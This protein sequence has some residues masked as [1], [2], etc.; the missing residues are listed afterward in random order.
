MNEEVAGRARLVLQVLEDFPVIH[1]MYIAAVK[2][3][4]RDHYRR[5]GD[6]QSSSVRPRSSIPAL[7]N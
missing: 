3:F 7:Q 4:G 6:R 5:E 2:Y 1:V